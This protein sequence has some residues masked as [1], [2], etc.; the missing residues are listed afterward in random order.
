SSQ[1]ELQDIFQLQDML[2]RGVVE[3][4]ALPLSTGEQH[5]LVHDS[6]AS[7]KAYDL[8]LRATELSRNHDAI[9]AAVQLYE[10]CVALDPAYAPAWAGLGRAHHILS[11]YSSTGTRE[12]LGR[13]EAAFQRA[14]ELNPGLPIAHRLLAQLEFDLGRA[15]DAMVRLA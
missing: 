11:K 8:F 13:A 5:Q 6:P 14:L 2:V 12:G 10:Q 3:S 1:V 7:P 15:R 9:P 4:L